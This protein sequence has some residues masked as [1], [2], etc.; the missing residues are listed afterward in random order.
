VTKISQF[1]AQTVNNINNA[2]RGSAA[3]GMIISID[4]VPLARS[5]PAGAGGVLYEFIAAVTK[6]PNCKADVACP[7]YVVCGQIHFV[8]FEDS[9]KALTL[10][11]NHDVQGGCGVNA[12]LG[13]TANASLAT[14]WQAMNLASNLQQT[15]ATTLAQWGSNPRHMM[16][17]SYAARPT[18]ALSQSFPDFGRMFQ[19]TAEITAKPVVWPP[20]N[21]TCTVHKF[22]I[23]VLPSDSKLGPQSANHLWQNAGDLGP[24]AAS[25]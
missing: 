14:N 13:L 21:G 6:R 18:S 24:C 15:M 1:A 12:Q 23:S 4:S 3:M 19:I 20:S 2:P 11:E 16:G 17:V 10:V 25:M 7:M 8:V 5:E 22:L 9:S